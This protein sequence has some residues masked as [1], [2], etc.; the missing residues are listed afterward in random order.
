LRAISTSKSNWLRIFKKHCSHTPFPPSKIETNS[1][2]NFKR[3]SYKKCF[4]PFFGQKVSK[5]FHFRRSFSASPSMDGNKE[6]SFQLSCI[7]RLPASKVIF[8][9]KD[10]EMIPTL[11]PLSWT[12]FRFPFHLYSIYKCGFK[13]LSHPSGNIVLPVHNLFETPKMTW[14]LNTKS[15]VQTRPIQSNQTYKSN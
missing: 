8:F 10:V 13:Q 7:I 4:P 11:Q 1:D 9:E 12:S 6:I 15:T 3:S 5:S 2:Q 14:T